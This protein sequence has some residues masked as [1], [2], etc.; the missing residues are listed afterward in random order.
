MTSATVTADALDFRSIAQELVGGN[1]KF[2]EERALVPTEARVRQQREGKNF[3][4]TP[5][6]LGATVDQEGLTNSY[7]VEP[8]MYYAV[9]P[10]PE[11]VKSYLFQGAIASLLVT[12]TLLTAFAVS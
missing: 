11:Q 4:R 3:M 7:A 9:Y 5:N 8:E 1:R 10:S 12:A 2:Q 6:A